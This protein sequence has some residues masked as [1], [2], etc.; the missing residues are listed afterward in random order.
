[1]DSKLFRITTEPNYYR[2]V[3]NTSPLV[4]ANTRNNVLPAPDS[5][6]P[7]WP[8][9]MSDGRLVTDYNNHCSKNI[10]V[11]KQ[12]PTTLWMQRNGNSIID[13]SRHANMIASGSIFPFDKSVVPPPESIVSCKRSGCTR[14]STGLEGGLGVE[15]N[16][17]V[18]EL[19]GTFSSVTN[20]LKPQKEHI[21]GT[22]NYEAG[23][24][25]LRGDFEMSSAYY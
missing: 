19:F 5:R 3:Q 18:P 10:P 1:M 7:A 24:N 25:S 20:P 12:Y 8:G 21:S 11:G 9:A 17:G 16:E 4:K 6:F 23:R 15:R 22:T 14:V 2:S 13:Y